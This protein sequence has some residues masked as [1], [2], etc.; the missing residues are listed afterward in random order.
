MGKIK[1]KVSMVTIRNYIYNVIKYMMMSSNCFFFTVKV[2]C[3]LHRAPL[4]IV[5][6][7]VII[8]HC[9][10]FNI[11]TTSILPNDQNASCL[12]L[13]FFA[14]LMGGGKLNLSD[15][16]FLIL[17]LIC[18]IIRV[19]SLQHSTTPRLINSSKLDNLKTCKNIE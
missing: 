18:I 8:Y 10:K 19:I 17:C 2:K 9:L 7:N 6:Q 11:F 15:I 5:F 14:F 16:L 1:N 3:I 12:L 13:F 4:K